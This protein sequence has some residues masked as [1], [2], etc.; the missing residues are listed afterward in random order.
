MKGAAHKLAL[1]GGVF[2]AG[3]ATAYSAGSDIKVAMIG[4]AYEPKSIVAKVGDVLV[5]MNDDTEPHEVFVPTVGFST[6][7]GRQEPGTEA[8]LPL[9]RP[10]TFEIECVFHQSMLTRVMVSP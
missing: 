7:L 4:S 3:A 8:R 1:A 10:G 6:D 2:L 9:L 5:F